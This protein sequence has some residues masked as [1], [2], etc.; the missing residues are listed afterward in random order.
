MTTMLRLAAAF[1]L[2]FALKLSAVPLPGDFADYWRGER[3]RLE[4]TVPLDPQVSAMPDGSSKPF[5]R[6]RVSFATFGGKRAYGFLAVP[7]DRSKGPFPVTVTVPGAGAGAIAGHV[8][9]DGLSVR[10]VMNV[11]PFEPAEERAEQQKRL[12]AF[13]SE[14]RKRWNSKASYPTMGL[15]SSRE[16]YF[17]HDAMLG[18]ARAVDWLAGQQ[19]VD[20]SRFVYIGGSQGG[21][22]G[23]ALTALTGRFT[24]TYVYVPAFCNVFS[25]EE[26]GLPPPWPNPLRVYAA[27]SAAERDAVRANLPYFDC[28]NFATLVTTPVKVVLGLSDKACPP[29]GIRTMFA[30]LESSDKELVEVPWMPHGSPSGEVAK[31]VVRWL[32]DPGSTIRVADV[33]CPALE[34]KTLPPVTICDAPRHSPLTLV[35]DSRPRFVIVGDF[36]KEAAVRGPE[37]QTLAK[38]RRDAKRRAA[39]FLQ[40][41]FRR[42]TGVAPDVMETDDPRAAKA[43]LVVAVGRTRHSDA[44]GVDAAKLPREG[45]AVKTFDRG[46]VLVGR[47]E[48]QEPGV[49]DKYVWR[50]CRITMNGTEWAAQD[51]AERFLGVRRYS[52]VPTGL[53][54]YV[55]SVTNLVLK[56]MHY[57]DYP[58]ISMRKQ[59][60]W[61]WRQAEATDLLCVEAPHPFDFAKAHPDRIEDCFYRDATGRLWQNPTSYSGNFFDITSDEFVKTLAADYRLYY[62]QNGTGTYWRASHAPSERC[63]WFCQVDH[64]LGVSNERAKPFLHADDPLSMSDVYAD[65][66]VRLGREIDRLLPGKRLVVAAYSNYV[67]PPRIVRKLPANIQV[68]VCMGTPVF[69]RSKKYMDLFIGTVK[70]WGAV[71]RGYKPAIYT[72]DASYSKDGVIEQ[73]LRGYFEGELLRAAWPYI[74]HE[75]MLPCVC[76]DN[77]KV[78][79]W[80]GYLTMRALWNPQTNPD[81]ILEEYF[82]RMFGPKA[83]P[84]LDGFYHDIVSRWVKFYLPYADEGRL[85]VSIPSPN[86]KRLYTTTFPA[87]VLKS[88]EA[89]LD[90]A[91]RAIAPGSQEAARFRQFAE[92]YRRTFQSIRDYQGIRYPELKVVKAVDEVVVDGRPDESAWSDAAPVSFRKGFAGG[93]PDVDGTTGRFLWDK[94]GLFVSFSSPAP[95]AVGQK[96][97][98][99]GDNMELMVSPGTSNEKVY[100]VVLSAA[101]DHEDIFR[102]LDPPRNGDSNWVCR[103][104]RKAVSRDDK[105]WSAEVFVPWDA[106]DAAP[107]KAGDVWHVNLISNR[108]KPTEYLSVSPT[109]NNN[110]RAEMYA[111][112]TFANVL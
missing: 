57:S 106:L 69:A 82:L 70:G 61:G 24:K 110:Y 94:R 66:Y 85:D 7:K 56:P 111:R 92:P 74:D 87:G 6:Y 108:T 13:N 38:F 35:A 32:H 14:L 95:Y 64:G 8:I 22:M 4:R 2:C 75:F 90:A 34:D 67:K 31:A 55:P 45:F 53:W 59:S 103:G 41:A 1:V 58:R 44:L 89:K 50:C 20:K 100:Q 97:V 18:I 79:N 19:Y 10:L 40:D 3:A 112:L 25:G 46:V 104:M 107:P 39:T 72:Y 83:G 52:P 93:K 48:F 26:Q 99:S 68:E 96:G 76:H 88:L 27:A 12:D 71:A 77:Y 65:F 5:V 101:G 84:V 11:H 30:A 86:L 98:W 54:D 51:F 80:S 36:K 91:E 105:G 60:S 47:D 78:Y 15:A 63:M 29:H 109:L 17:F 23:I 9:S 62:D 102:Q 21:Y 43:D 49:A 73:S 16:D 42:T 81:A 28:A 33:W 37:G